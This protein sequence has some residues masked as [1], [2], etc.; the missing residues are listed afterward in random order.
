MHFI[1]G[2]QDM[3][4]EINGVKATNKAVRYLAFIQHTIKKT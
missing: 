1:G 2:F 3:F 4:N